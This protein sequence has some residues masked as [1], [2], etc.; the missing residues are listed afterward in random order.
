LPELFDEKSIAKKRKK[1]E[2]KCPQQNV[3]IYMGE[4]QVG[5]FPP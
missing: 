1:K 4:K 5:G 2:R 3:E